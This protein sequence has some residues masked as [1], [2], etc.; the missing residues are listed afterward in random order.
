[1]D[2]ELSPEQQALQQKVMDFCAREC[3]PEFETSLDQG[4]VFP[5]ELYGKM[6]DS[7][8]LRVSFP[9]EY[10]GTQGCILDV[11]LIAEGLARTS[12]TAV[13]LYLV[14]V[15]FAGSMILN[16][17]SEA[18]KK[19]FLPKLL[20]GGLRFSFALTEPDAGSDAR[21]IKTSAAARGDRFFIS[22]TKY[23]TSGATVSDY[24][25]T[26]VR[27]G[28]ETDPSRAMSVFLVPTKGEGLSVTPIPKLAGNA[29]PSCEVK[30]RD[31]AV[32][33]EDI[34]GGPEW[35]HNGLLQ[36]FGT[37]A[38]ERI[39]VAAS[40]LGG[41]EAILQECTEFAK[42][43]Q[44][45]NKPIMKFQAIQHALA[46]IATQ[47]EAMRWMTY[48]AAW[49]QSVGRECFKEIC[50][51]KLFCSETLNDIARKGMQIFGGRGYSME[52]R[53]QRYLRESYLSLYAGGTSEIQ[54]NVIARFL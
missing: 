14:N 48:H 18:Q 29:Y 8:L 46:D 42:N 17:G 47:M 2:M 20:N 33:K 12:Y 6:A 22:G 38:Y 44:Q 3:P 31:V 41:A 27:T 52:Y 50:M 5:E 36:L 28:A 34:L 10:G 30:Y 43:R 51:A 25:I 39:C 15:V 23:W 19:A 16:S 11:V 35:L 7:G 1:M 26:V 49:M 24:I 40:C 37:A 4:G 54:K 45:F 9:E 32:G 13:Y 21:S 53:M